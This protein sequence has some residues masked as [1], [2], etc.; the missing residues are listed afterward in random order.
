MNPNEIG[1]IWELDG[2]QY[3]ILD[4][5][6][7]IHSDTLG[8]IVMYSYKPVDD[9]KYRRHHHVC[10]SYEFMQKFK[11]VEEC[12]LDSFV[13][14]PK[15]NIEFKAPVLDAMRTLKGYGIPFEIK[16]KGIHLILND[17]IDFWPTTG[18]FKVR[19]TDASGKGLVAVMQTFRE[20]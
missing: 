4:Q 15:E 13:I 19:A 5:L 14:P 3:V 8:T 1:S 7:P 2:I 18:K 6:T 16:N 11:R 17:L 12:P 20:L 10:E 9:D